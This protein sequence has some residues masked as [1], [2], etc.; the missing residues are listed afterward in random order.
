MKK[1]KANEKIYWNRKPWPCVIIS[2]DPGKHAGASILSSKGRDIEVHYVQTVETNSVQVEG[3]IVKAID[4]AYKLRLKLFLVTETWGAGG[5]MGIDQWC[6]LGAARGAWERAMHLYIP[7]SSNVIVKS[8]HKTRINCQTWRAWMIGKNG[9]KN[10]GKFTRFDDLGWKDAAKEAIPKFYPKLNVEG[11][12]HNALES[13]LIGTHA[14]RSDEV[15][16]LLTKK[17]RKQHEQ[18]NRKESNY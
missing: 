9:E 10:G 6:G 15:G 5:P 17:E 2:V 1:T 7:I 8:R 3:M 14:F 4:V 16:K 11:L 12:D 13:V 18:D